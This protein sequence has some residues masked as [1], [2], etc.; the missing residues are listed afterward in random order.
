MRAALRGANGMT[1]L[2]LTVA[3]LLGMRSRFGY[4]KK[5][6]LSVSEEL[7]SVLAPVRFKLYFARVV[8]TSGARKIRHAV[9]QKTLDIALLPFLQA[10]SKQRRG[11]L[12][13]E[14][15]KAMSTHHIAKMFANSVHWIM[16]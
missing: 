5:V 2:A 9:T 4:A 13:K 3:Q 10:G 7:G 8:T 16:S 12:L 14:T 6:H 11:A 15:R 1:G